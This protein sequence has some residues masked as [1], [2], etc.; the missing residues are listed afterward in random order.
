MS[1]T[2]TSARAIVISRRCSGLVGDDADDPDHYIDPG[3][4]LQMILG[5]H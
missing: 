4:R 2:S 5:R 3:E 1:L